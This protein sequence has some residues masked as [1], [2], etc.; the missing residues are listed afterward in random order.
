MFSWTPESMMDS[1]Q[2]G[3]RPRGRPR[4][5]KNK[6]TAGAVG[7]PPK[8]GGEPQRHIV[9]DMGMYF[10]LIR[11]SAIAGTLSSPP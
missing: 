6:S 8:N 10:R 7:R 5:S 1:D 4:G 11:L 9:Y 2:H 3:R